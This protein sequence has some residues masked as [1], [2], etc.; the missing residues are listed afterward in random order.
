M[1]CFGVAVVPDSVALVA[2]Q[3]SASG[4]V[5][6]LKEEFAEQTLKEEFAPKR[7]DNSDWSERFRVNF[8]Q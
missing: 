7:H 5:G 3:S 6:T 4:R 1:G 8:H 2:G